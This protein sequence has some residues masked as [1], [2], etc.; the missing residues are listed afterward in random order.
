MVGSALLRIVMSFFKRVVFVLMLFFSF[1]ISGCFSS[2]DKTKFISGSKD[3]SSIEC[4]SQDFSIFLERFSEDV[5]IQRKF[6]IY[7]LRRLVRVDELSPNE[8][9]EGTKEIIEYLEED[10]VKFPLIYNEKQLVNMGL[11]LDKE[12]RGDMSVVIERSVGEKYLGWYVEYSFVKKSCWNLA[13]ISD[14][15]T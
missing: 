6:T 7:P 3:Q 13:E 1:V 11:K 9:S 12:I 4:P 5:E 14:Q 10:K 2:D 8:H 15:S